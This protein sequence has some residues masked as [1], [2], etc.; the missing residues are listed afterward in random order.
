MSQ[1]IYRLWRVK[2]FCEPYYQLSIEEQNDL[3]AKD[4][5]AREE[6]GGKRI[7]VCD[8]AWSNE[9]ILMFGIEEFPNIEAVQKHSKIL[10]EHD[11]GRYLVSDSILGTERHLTTAWL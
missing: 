2:R 5:N 8:S 9:Q 11:W 4:K 3:L 1:K 10:M 6:V 7:M